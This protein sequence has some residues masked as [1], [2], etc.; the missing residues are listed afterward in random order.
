LLGLVLVD[1]DEKK[2]Y[3]HAT[4]SGAEEVWKAEAMNIWRK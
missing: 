1:D 3:V 4:C 2:D